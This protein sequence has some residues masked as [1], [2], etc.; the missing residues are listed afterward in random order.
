LGIGLVCV[1]GY[2]S[3]FPVF[4]ELGMGEDGADD[5]A[6]LVSCAAED[7]DEFGHG[8]G[9]EQSETGAMD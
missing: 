3:D 6:A 8:E 7:G 5:G 1:S 2:A 9:E 4:A